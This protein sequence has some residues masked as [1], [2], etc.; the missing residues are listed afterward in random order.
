MWVP[1]RSVVQVTWGRRDQLQHTGDGR[2]FGVWGS[3]L[4]WLLWVWTPSVLVGTYWLQIMLG[5]WG[6][7][8]VLWMIDSH[9]SVSQRPDSSPVIILE[10]W[11]LPMMGGAVSQ[12]GLFQL[13]RLKRQV[14]TNKQCWFHPRSP[15]VFIEDKTGS[16]VGEMGIGVVMV[17][18]SKVVLL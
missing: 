7:L 17:S 18:T 14:V 1:Q 11:K 2:W 3:R 9:L 12:H 10:E 16:L 15:A 13:F 4:W 6:R 5:L 8:A